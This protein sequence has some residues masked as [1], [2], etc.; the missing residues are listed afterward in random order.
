MIE[1]KLMGKRACV[2]Q[3]KR[4]IDVFPKPSITAGVGG[5]GTIRK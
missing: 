3:E 4:M 1:E 5:K 2:E